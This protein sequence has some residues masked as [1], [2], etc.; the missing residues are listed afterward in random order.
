MHYTTFCQINQDADLQKE[1]SGSP[2]EL[3]PFATNTASPTVDRE[4]GICKERMRRNSERRGAS[5]WLNPLTRS[6]KATSKWRKQKKGAQ[7]KCS[8]LFATSSEVAIWRRVRDLNPRFS[9]WRTQHFECC[10]FDLSDNSP[11]ILFARI[12][13]T[14]FDKLSIANVFYA[15]ILQNFLCLLIFVPFAIRVAICATPQNLL[16]QTKQ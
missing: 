5:R 8:F 11:Y 14:T 1:K 7:I 2:C 4:L 10:T 15:S 3:L 6:N 12:S 13:Y 16:H 9:L